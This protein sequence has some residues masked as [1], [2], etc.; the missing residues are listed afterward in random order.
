[1]K[2]FLI[3][4]SIALLS[5][6]VLAPQADARR[7]GGGGTSGMQRSVPPRSASTTPPPSQNAAPT[8]APTTPGMASPAAAPKRSWLGPLAGLAA[9]LGIAALMSH[10]GMG[11]EFGNIVMLALLAMVAFIAIRFV[12]SRF[13][14][15][16]ETQGMQY[17]GAAAGLGNEPSGQLPAN[18]WGSGAALP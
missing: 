14:S 13:G 9:G 5:L 16:P 17:A 10:L 2:R 4:L 1:M 7:L 6:S 11:A 15:R 12:M 3:S 8:A 18:G